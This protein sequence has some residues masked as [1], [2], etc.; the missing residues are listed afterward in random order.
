MQ[1]P[2]H[3]FFYA[4]N[5]NR[6]ANFDRAKSDKL[7]QD[8]DFVVS[9]TVLNKKNPDYHEAIRERLGP[10]VS[11]MPYIFVDGLY[12]ASATRNQKLLGG[13]LGDSYIAAELE[14]REV[15][16]VLARFKDGA[17]DFNHKDRLEKSLKELRRREGVCDYKLYDRV[18][19]ECLEERIMITHNHPMPGMLN[20]LATQIADAHGLKFE[21]VDASHPERYKAMML[22][23][24]A[25]ILSPFT[26][27][28]IGAAYPAD[29][30]WYEQGTEL[31]CSVAKAMGKSLKGIEKTAPRKKRFF[32]LI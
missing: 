13:V 12:S 18:S 5:S 8:A 19:A 21:P 2:D 16:E 9:Q 23:R 3:E 1:N 31:V 30:D 14:E 26:I 20:G 11:L 22:P 28:D 10:K 24:G 7:M 4:G 29:D 25:Q 27:A 15:P 6:V 32:G 17:L